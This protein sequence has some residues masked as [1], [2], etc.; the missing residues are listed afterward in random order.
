MLVNELIAISL[1][2]MAVSTLESKEGVVECSFPLKNRR[3]HL[4]WPNG[5]TFHECCEEYQIEL[6]AVQLGHKAS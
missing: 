5:T 3:G 6:A 1:M 4:S 2:A